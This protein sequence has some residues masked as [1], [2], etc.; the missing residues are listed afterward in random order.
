MVGYGKYSKTYRIWESGTKIVE[1]R[2]V[3]CIET[4]PV[5]LNAFDHD[6][7]DGS[8]DAFLDLESTSISLGTQEK[9]PATEA[10][11]EP[12]TGDSQSGGARSNVDEESDSDVDEG[13]DSDIDSRPSEALKAKRIARQLRQLGDYNK[14]PA[15][16]NVTAIYPSTLC[17]LYTS[18]S[19]R[20]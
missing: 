6:H 14:G 16:A 8:N 4:L 12:D 19:P 7:N 2:N 18:P 20:D 1:S 15:S 3:T 17:L 11:A 5:K 13:S 9:M 10:D